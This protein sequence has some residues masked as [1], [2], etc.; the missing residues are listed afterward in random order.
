MPWTH[1][2]LSWSQRIIFI[3]QMLKE[4][5]PLTNFVAMVLLPVSLLLTGLLSPSVPCPMDALF[6]QSLATAHYLFVAV[7]L[8]TKLNQ[9]IN[10][11]HINLRRVRNL[12][13][14]DIWGAPREH[15]SPSP[16]HI[17]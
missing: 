10:H 14:L 4:Y 16:F 17:F 8:T 12:Q 1:I 7:Y 9:Y 2:R 5:A 3:L 11:V 15:E 13:S 6:A